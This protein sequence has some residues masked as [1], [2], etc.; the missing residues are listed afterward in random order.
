MKSS[1]AGFILIMLLST[2]FQQ[3]RM[4]I[5]PKNAHQRSFKNVCFFTAAYILNRGSEYVISAKSSIK[6]ILVLNAYR[7]LAV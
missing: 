6:V 4:L 5:Y 3:E 7:L 2:R 1:T